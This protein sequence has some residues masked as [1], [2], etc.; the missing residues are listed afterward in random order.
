[1]IITKVI[2]NNIVRS[3]NDRGQEVLLLGK[4][5]G[6]RKRIAMIF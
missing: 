5:L 3:I 4:T 2:N 1:M 6:F